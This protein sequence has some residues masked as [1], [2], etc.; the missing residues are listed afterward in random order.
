MVISSEIIMQVFMNIQFLAHSGF[1][2]DDGVRYYVFDYYQDPKGL[3]EVAFQ[4]GRDIWFF[5]SHLHGDHYNPDIKRFDSDHTRYIVHE[6]VPL[7]PGQV[8]APVTK[9]AVYDSVA[10]DGN[11]FIKMYGSTDLGGSFLVKAKDSFFHA[12]DLNWWHW[13]GDTPENIADAKRMAW[14][15]L[16]RLKGLTVDYAMFPV[17]NR[18]EYAQEWGILEFLK[19]VRV[20]KRLIPMHLFGPAWEPSPYYQALYGQV[21]LWNV[22][23]E[24]DSWSD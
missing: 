3:V 21:P 14:K 9:M 19:Y 24:G 18:L 6:D 11:V 12:G 16:G 5:V 17:D 4:T 8:Q 15:E 20:T 23:V 7:D 10:L 2:L 1:L 22:S 13:W